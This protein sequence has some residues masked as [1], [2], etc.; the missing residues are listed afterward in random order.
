M[1]RI[2]DYLVAYTEEP[3]GSSRN[4]NGRRDASAKGGMKLRGELT[5][6]SD[7]APAGV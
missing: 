3:L 4:R 1:P 7:Q 5:S 2:L 6:S